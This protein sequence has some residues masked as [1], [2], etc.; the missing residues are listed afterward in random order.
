MSKVKDRGVF[1]LVFL[2]E[3]S[4]IST[5]NM[6]NITANVKHFNFTADILIFLL[7]LAKFKASR[8]IS[9]GTTLRS[10]LLLRSK[11]YVI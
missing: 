2:L 10:Y 8:E 11:Q 6:A 9:G 5:L 1:L 7:N 3:K 4:M